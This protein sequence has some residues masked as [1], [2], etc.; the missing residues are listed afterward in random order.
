MKCQ[1]KVSDSD[2]LKVDALIG[3]WEQSKDVFYS[4]AFQ[5]WQQAT[6]IVMDS[7]ADDLPNDRRISM[8]LTLDPGETRLLRFHYLG[9][10]VAVTSAFRSLSGDRT[11]LFSTT[12]DLYSI[13]PLTLFHLHP[14]IIYLVFPLF[15]G[16]VLLMPYLIPSHL[17]TNKKLLKLALRTD[18]Y[19]FWKQTLD[20][21]RFYVLVEF[22]ELRRIYNPKLKTDAEEV[23]DYFRTRLTREYQA[24]GWR[25]LRRSRLDEF[26]KDELRIL[27]LKSK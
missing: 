16:L 13:L 12:S 1:R 10:T 6:D 8:M 14:W 23:V 9:N 4:E 21:Y 2:C 27:V 25:F 15:F 26:I 11:T 19:E 3:A 20:R 17:L 22:R 7:N 5:K 18:D 24:G